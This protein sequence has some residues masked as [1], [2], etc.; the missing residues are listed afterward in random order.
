[1]PAGEINGVQTLLVDIQSLAQRANEFLTPGFRFNRSMFDRILAKFRPR[2]GETND[3]AARRIAA[4]QQV[5]SAEEVRQLIA[6]TVGAIGAV[7]VSGKLL[8][9]Q[10]VRSEQERAANHAMQSSMID[11]A[12]LMWTSLDE[13]I[14]NM[15][16]RRAQG[17]GGLGNPLVIVAIIGVAAVVYVVLGVSA[18]V[19]LTYLVDSYTRAQRA[20]SAADSICRAQGGC[21]PEQ[22]A[23]IQHS[24][25]VGPFD[26]AIRDAGSG[27][28][29]V[30]TAVGV[31]GVIVGVLGIGGVAYYLWR[32]S[33]GL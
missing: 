25:S 18:I 22:R 10:S 20:E 13:A 6:G 4:A 23:A 28:R 5:M 30:I 17:T 3:Q 27:V 7:I 31:T 33:R 11:P 8:A 15:Q 19:A 26:Q 2:S 24:L 9:Q 16:Q 1:M 14:N 29:D 21:T 32:K 12:R